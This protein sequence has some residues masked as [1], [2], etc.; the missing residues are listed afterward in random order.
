MDLQ[1][2]DE[3]PM[4]IH[5][6]D[7]FRRVPFYII[8][9]LLA[10][11]SVTIDIMISLF[12][13]LNFVGLILE[14]FIAYFS[15]IVCIVFA[16]LAM[17]YVYYKIIDMLDS[18]KRN[19]TKKEN[20][21][22]SL[23][24]LE[25]KLSFLNSFK[26][27]FMVGLIVGVVYHAITFGY[28]VPVYG[29]EPYCVFSN[30]IWSF[31]IGIGI[32]VVI[33]GFKFAVRLLDIIKTHN[34]INLTHE[35]RMGGLKKLTTLAI[36]VFVLSNITFGLWIGSLAIPHMSDNLILTIFIAGLFIGA[37]LLGLGVIKLHKTMVNIKEAEL[38]EIISSVQK[39][40]E[41]Y[42]ELLEKK[43]ISWIK[44]IDLQFAI[45]LSNFKYRVAEDLNTWPFS[46]K[47]FLESL[48]S[49]LGL[50]PT[51]LQVIT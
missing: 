11:F 8:I 36:R 20:F 18:L 40:E 22:K 44:T 34:V 26:Q 4:G 51:I 15:R 35:D 13:R 14:Q 6:L 25:P 28:F 39:M 10:V 37:T 30:A 42:Q 17:R 48:L 9:M 41:E 1:I 24:I 19:F 2:D 12:F 3:Y 32:Y 43:K 29:W 16:F 5:Y 31:I 33:Y 49:L 45:S 38:K 27:H 7:R 21:I 23:L 47:M 50:V 46:F